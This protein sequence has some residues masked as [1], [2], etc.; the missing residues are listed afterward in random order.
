MKPCLII[1]T[2]VSLL[3]L[4]LHLPQTAVAE[5]VPIP[6]RSGLARFDTRTGYPLLNKLQ[7][8]TRRDSPFTIPAPGTANDPRTSPSSYR[9]CRYPG[10][11]PCEFI[12]LNPA[13][14]QPIG[15]PPGSKGWKYRGG[16][17]SVDPCRSIIVRR[18][19][20]KITCIGASSLSDGF[21]VPIGDG[22][23]VD[24]LV[25]GDLRYCTKF[26][27]PFRKDSPRRGQWRS[28]G[29][30]APETCLDIDAPATP[31]PATPTPSNAPT[32]VP[33]PQPTAGPTP[34]PTAEPPPPPPYGSASQAFVGKP[35]GLTR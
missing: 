27:P 14:W 29:A 6:G 33:T 13:R 9:K 1:A 7:S 34:A 15:K 24:E 23:V 3:V 26:D 2:L 11:A 20:I 32:P 30:H 22:S 25:I 28:R 10:F 5:D 17:T 16:G 8:K 31:S 18:D 35:A 4:S 21:T 19:S 12:H